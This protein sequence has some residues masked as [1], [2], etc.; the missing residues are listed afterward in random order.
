MKISY[1]SKAE[2]DEQGHQENIRPVEWKK[3]LQTILNAFLSV[4][5]EWWHP[6]TTKHEAFLIDI[7]IVSIVSSV[8]LRHTI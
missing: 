5:F 3:K 6:E 2:A 8:C 4:N 7:E 1:M